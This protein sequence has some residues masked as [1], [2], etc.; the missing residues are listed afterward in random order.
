MLKDIF[1]FMHL[2]LSILVSL[3][4]ISVT[5]L[6]CGEGVWCYEIQQLQKLQNRAARIITGSSYDAP[7]KPL[8]ETLSWKTNKET[9]QFES[10]IMVFKIN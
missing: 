6:L 1:L 10:Q 9:I 5:A 4:F 7:S 3:T 2:K 8:L